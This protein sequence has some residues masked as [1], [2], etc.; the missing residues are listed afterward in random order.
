MVDVIDLTYEAAA[1]VF[2]NSYTAYT[3]S[4]TNAYSNFT[5]DRNFLLAVR[6]TDVVSVPDAIELRRR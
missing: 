1:V 4:T 3:S 2:P 6:I 5:S